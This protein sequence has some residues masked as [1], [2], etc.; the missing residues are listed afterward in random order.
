MKYSSRKIFKRISKVFLNGRINAECLKGL[1]LH[2]K[3]N[4]MS[5]LDDDNIDEEF[6]S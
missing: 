4:A 3:T 2:T 6:L 5:K 1:L